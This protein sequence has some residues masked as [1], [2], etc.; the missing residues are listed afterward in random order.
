MNK[1]K[2]RNKNKKQK[3]KEDDNDQRQMKKKITW[4]SNSDIL[5]YWQERTL[6]YGKS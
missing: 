5:I 1:P 4:F 2:T 6:L 3:T